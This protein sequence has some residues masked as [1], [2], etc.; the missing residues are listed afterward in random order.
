MPEVPLASLTFEHL[1][2]YVRQ[3][4]G[5]QDGPQRRGWRPVAGSITSIRHFL[6]RPQKLTAKGKP[7]GPAPL[8]MT[9][10]IVEVGRDD[11]GVYHREIHALSNQK[12]DLN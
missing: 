3:L 2:R 5:Q 10:L 8:Q 6:D 12:V 7:T 1:G 4:D 11:R 9:S